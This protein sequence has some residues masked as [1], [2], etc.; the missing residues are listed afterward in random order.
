MRKMSTSPKN[1]RGGF[2]LIELLVVIAI[3]A[4]LIAL[5]LPAVQQARES[6]RRTQCKN[7][8]KQI[9]L[10]LHNFHD[11]YGNFPPG[12]LDDDGR[13][14]CWRT[15]LL[16]YMDQAP[17]YQS[18]TSVG[19]SAGTL[20]A[21]LFPRGG[22]PNLIQADTSLV[23]QTDNGVSGV[24]PTYANENEV[25]K[26]HG[27]GAGKRVMGAWA[28]PSDVLS[29]QDNDGYGKANYCGSSGT[30]NYSPTVPSPNTN[31]NGC[32]SIKGVNQNGLLVYSND[33]N[34]GYVVK[35][36]DATDGL[37]NTIAVGECTVVQTQVTAQNNGD[38]SFPIWVGGNNNG[39]C[40]GWDSGGSSM[41]LTNPTMPINMWKT[42]TTAALGTMIV[43]TEVLAAFGSQHVGG[44]Q[45]LM[46]DGSVI[47]LSENMDLRIY[48]NIGSRNDGQPTGSY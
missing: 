17:I 4:V 8:L 27:L 21:Q 26:N 45:F 2:T 14:Y 46:D 19:T 24:T 29:K 37:S 31:W 5:L 6:A 38:G 30:I 42:Y 44:C 41:K 13:N 16:P 15:Y 48:Q 9:G 47:F 1:Q 23:F 36:S 11:V 43:D 3:I 18:L 35:I 40:D 39:G 10:A 12:M 33:N 32:A 22:V 28:C 7:N 34:A 20:G 25:S